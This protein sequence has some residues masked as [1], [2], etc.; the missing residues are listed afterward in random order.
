[1]SKNSK[2]ETIPYQPSGLKWSDGSIGADLPMVKLSELFNVNFFIVSQVNPHMVPYL[3]AKFAVQKRHF[4]LRWSFYFIWDELKHRLMQVVCC[5][6]LN[7]SFPS[8]D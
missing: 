2:G 5:H 1:M 3:N 8:W 7:L 6:P 4:L